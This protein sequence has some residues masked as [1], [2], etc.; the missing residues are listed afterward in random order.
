V[1]VHAGDI[2]PARHGLLTPARVAFGTVALMVV[3]SP[4]GLLAP[5][6]AFGEDAPRDLPLGDLGLSAVPT[7]LARYAGFWSHT[8][9][10]GYGFSDGRH[11][12]LG[13][14]LSALVGIVAIGLVVFVVAAAV[15]RLTGARAADPVEQPAA[16]ATTT[17]SR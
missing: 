6:G 7:G 12:T 5:G 11:T 1:P 16:S 13:Y 17:P 15:S 4:I 14:I 9:L 2:V 10:G 3:L 8:L